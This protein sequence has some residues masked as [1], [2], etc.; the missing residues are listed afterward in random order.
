MK[1]AI[2][3]G[4][5]VALAAISGPI[6]AQKAHAA[7]FPTIDGL[8]SGTGPV[9]YGGVLELPVLGRGGVPASGVDA[10]AINVTVTNPTM[11]SY[12][13][14]WPTGSPQPTAAN[15]Y[16]LE[17]FHADFPIG[18]E[19]PPMLGREYDRTRRQILERLAA[20]LQGNV[21]KEA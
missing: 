14:V 11:P 21:R 16:K 4:L 18:L 1:R 5:L 6:G 15:S 9:G 3:A 17:P 12:V 7:G 10:V 19:Y 2:F 13:T 8:F 20:N